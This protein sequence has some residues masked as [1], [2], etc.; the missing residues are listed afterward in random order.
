M[1]KK[2]QVTLPSNG[3]PYWYVRV[4]PLSVQFE[5]RETTWQDFMMDRIRYA[6][7]N[8]FINEKDA[9]KLEM[10]QNEILSMMPPARP[11]SKKYM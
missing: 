6:Q 3:T 4:N 9:L 1:K 8:F 2:E 5:A 7:G 10:V 11:G